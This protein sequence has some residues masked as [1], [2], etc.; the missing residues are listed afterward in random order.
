MNSIIK[1]ANGRQ[2][3]SFGSVV[4]QIFQNNLPRLFDDS[5]WGFTG[6]R[7]NHVP[8]NI[9]ET[10][11]SYEL[12]VVAPGLKKEDF[13]LNLEADLL[14]ISVEDKTENRQ[15]AKS[16]GWLRQEFVRQSFSRSFSLDNTINKE[17]ITA[18][19]E[20]GV[21]YITLPKIEQAQKLTRL[22]DIQ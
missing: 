21:L 11:K 5:F 3:A 17:G 2:P 9:Q 6:I 19:Y 15:E 16:E 22:I 10:D 8:V 1:K 18:R 14:T 13:Q 20:N 7:Q 4:D 12:Q